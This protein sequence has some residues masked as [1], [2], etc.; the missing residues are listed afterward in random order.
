VAGTL[1]LA[2]YDGLQVESTRETVYRVKVDQAQ[3]GVEVRTVWNTSPRYRYRVRIVA[4]EVNDEATDL[5]T[6]IEDQ[7]GSGDSFTL[8]NDPV[9]GTSA[10]VRFE[11]PPRFEQYRIDG[12]WAVTL[13]MISVL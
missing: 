4:Q 10:T 5:A 9:T 8:V 13:E 7:Y 2:D 1:T 3:N 6:F 11:S 12:W